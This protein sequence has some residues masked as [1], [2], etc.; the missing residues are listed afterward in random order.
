LG[1]RREQAHCQHQ[2][3]CGTAAQPCG[4]IRVH[5]VHDGARREAACVCAFLAR[6]CRG[7][8]VIGHQQLSS[9]IHQ[10]FGA[11]RANLWLS[12]ASACV[13]YRARGRGNSLVD[14]DV[15]I[16]IWKCCSAG[17]ASRLTLYFASCDRHPL[18][19]GNAAVVVVEIFPC[20]LP[21]PPTHTHTNHCHPLL[22]HFYAPQV[23]QRC[24][25]HW[26]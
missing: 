16:P 21:P 15:Y 13:R 14:T 18:L 5:H 11:C 4:C 1:G 9:S 12:H 22:P 26:E 20:Q 7:K 23:S 8:G 25:K 19:V 6:G 17:G 2:Q 10:P 3:P 24:A